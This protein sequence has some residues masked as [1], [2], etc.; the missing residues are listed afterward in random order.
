MMMK[1]MKSLLALLLCLAMLFAF[2]GCGSSEDKAAGNDDKTAAG[3]QSADPENK[4]Q[5]KTFDVG[6]FSVKVPSGWKE[7]VVLATDGSGDTDTNSIDIIKG[8]SV[9][10]DAYIR[11]DYY[12]PSVTMMELS[13]TYYDDVEELEDMEIGGYKWHGFK[14]TAGSKPLI[15]LQTEAGDHEFQLAI[16]CE[17]SDGTISLDDADVKMIIESLTP[18]A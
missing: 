6:E 12:G 11:V 16:W 8:S 17:G 1:N 13:S 18:N 3:Q 5:A 7:S 4:P 15:N 2:V 14:C 10:S 9:F